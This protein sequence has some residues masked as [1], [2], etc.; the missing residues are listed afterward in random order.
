MSRTM[1]L[2]NDGCTA[3]R[4]HKSTEAVHPEPAPLI[5]HPF[6]LCYMRR[7]SRTVHVCCP[8]SLYA[9][10]SVGEDGDS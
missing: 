1:V 4:T 3:L 10:A 9:L 2:C 8:L 5:G 6:W 7:A